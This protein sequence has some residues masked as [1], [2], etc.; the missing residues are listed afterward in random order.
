MTN[1]ELILQR[2]DALDAKIDPIIKGRQRWLEL[3]DDLVPLQHQAFQLVMDQL[4]EVEAGFQL[5]DL[6]L[7]IKQA[8]RSVQNMQFIL[9][10]MDSFIELFLDIE[11][12]LKSAVP[13]IIETLDDM[14]QR[15]VFRIIK[16]MMDVRAKVAATY[17]AT[18]IEQISDGVVAML[19]VAKKMSDP[20]VIEF[21]EKA[22]AL[23][24]EVDL[25]NAKKVGPFGMLSAGFNSEVKEG[26]G[27]M[28]ALT[29]AMGKM[30]GNGESAPA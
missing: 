28:M 16:A 17:D 13:K 19:K 5:E 2:L 4:Q 29:K 6:M 9:K 3:R 14:E 15:G 1:E 7:L 18:D 20:K 12:L 21:M 26:L 23:P 25:Q 24:G 27:V 22:A 30:K 11:P 10:A 8:M